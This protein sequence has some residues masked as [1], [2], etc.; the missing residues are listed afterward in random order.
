MKWRKGIQAE[1][2]KLSFYFRQT[3]VFCICVMV[4][5]WLTLGDTA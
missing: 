2:R 5:G 1:V 3:R 4:F